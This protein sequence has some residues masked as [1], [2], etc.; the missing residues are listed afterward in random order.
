MKKSWIAHGHRYTAPILLIT[1][2]VLFIIPA[3][4]CAQVEAQDDVYDPL[5][6]DKVWEYTKVDN[7]ATFWKLAWSFEGDMVAATFFDNKCVVLSASN[8][9]VIKELDFNSGRGSRCDGFSPEGTNPL[10]ACAFS[11]DGKYLAVGG[12]DMEVIVLNVT[13]WERKYTLLGHTGSILS[14]DF[15]PDGR[16]LAS[17]SGRD[18]VIPQNAGEN[19][20]RIWDM[21]DGSEVI[22]LEGHSDGVLGVKWS[23]SGDKIATASD[24]RTVRIWSFPQGELIHNMEGHTTG[25]LDVDWSPDDSKLITGSRDYKIKVWNTSTGTLL[26]TWGDNNC[27]RSVDVHP[28]GELAATSGVDLTLKIRDMDTGTQLRV[29]KDGVAQNA[30]VMSSRW[31]PDGSAL[32]SGLGKSHTVIMYKFG[33]GTFK[34]EEDVGLRTMVI[35]ILISIVFLI[36][37]YYP[38]IKKIKKRRG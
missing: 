38:V 18:K 28:N 37:L 5:T 21:E 31:S 23:Y 27:V 6:L 34:E 17:G 29:I 16:Y 33:V 1:V 9:S 30:M 4:F 25:L 3:L 24:D 26:S 22:A 32:A 12:D 20:T 14:L 2:Y 8:G 11:P 19:I 36:L 35:L 10:R 15:S 13:T 7:E